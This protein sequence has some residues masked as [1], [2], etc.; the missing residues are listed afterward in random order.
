MGR[1]FS[2]HSM[3]SRRARR[4]LSI[5]LALALLLAQW[6]G[7]AHSFEHVRYELALAHQAAALAK[8]AAP[9]GAASNAELRA[10]VASPSQDSQD[11]PPA[12]SHARDHCLVFHALDCA[13]VAP[14]LPVLA[15][16][17]Q[18][19][20]HAQAVV[21][22]RPGSTPPFLSRAPPVFS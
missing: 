14:E 2:L 15:A 16:A 11:A 7:L 1:L 5:P 18:A 3:Q 8:P 13:A 6:A 4:F 10:G 22:P 17:V 12:L 21:R 19:V 20:L 9:D